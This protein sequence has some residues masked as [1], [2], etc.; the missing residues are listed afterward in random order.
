[1]IAAKTWLFSPFFVFIGSQIFPFRKFR[2]DG[3]GVL[4]GFRAVGRGVLGGFRGDAICGLVITKSLF[5]YASAD[6]QGFGDLFV[7]HA[8][9][10]EFGCLLGMLLV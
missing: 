7:I 4:G 6:I 8:Q 10:V 5:D 1:M 9:E 3:R 2:D